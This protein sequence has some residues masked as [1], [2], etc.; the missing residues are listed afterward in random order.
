VTV[1]DIPDPDI[2]YVGSIGAHPKLANAPPL[3]VYE[4]T[5]V[6]VDVDAMNIVHGASGGASR[7]T[8]GAASRG[9]AA[10]GVAH[11]VAAARSDQGEHRERGTHRR[12]LPAGTAP[13]LTFAAARSTILARRTWMAVE[14]ADNRAR[15]RRQ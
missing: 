14:S 4:R 15:W 9:V 10:S 1:A 2:Q 8:S 11:G 3:S 6:A 12:S 13:C 5:S 7:A